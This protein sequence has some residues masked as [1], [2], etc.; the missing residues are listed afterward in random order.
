MAANGRKMS[1]GQRDSTCGTKDISA[2]GKPAA[3]PR[4][5]YW[6]YHWHRSDAGNR[7]APQTSSSRGPGPNQRCSG[8]VK[9][10]RERDAESRGEQ[11]RAH[12]PDRSEGPSRGRKRDGGVKPTNEYQVESGMGPGN[13][14]GRP[15]RSAPWPENT[16]DGRHPV[17]AVPGK[18]WLVLLADTVEP[19]E[20]DPQEEA[21]EPMEVDPPRPHQTW[22]YPG[23]SLLRAMREHR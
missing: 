18:D 13:G 9:R 4:D 8:G 1:H 11:R 6:R 19:M 5:D 3:R 17:W 16:A 14:T 22:D 10:R 7:P 12:R 23:S 2:W 15:P 20:V 21:E